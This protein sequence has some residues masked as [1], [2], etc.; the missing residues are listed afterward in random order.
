VN[1][2]EPPPARFSVPDPAWR[3]SLFRRTEHALAP[4]PRRRV[5][6]V[7][8]NPSTA[9]EVLNDPT[10]SGCIRYATDWEFEEMTMLNVFA[11]RSTDP[12][13]LTGHPD[14]IGPDNDR[15]IAEEAAA[16]DL[17]VCCWG[18]HAELRERGRTVAELLAATGPMHVL[19][20]TKDGHPHHP[21]GLR[22]DLDPQPWRG[23]RSP[24]PKLGGTRR[25]VRRQAGSAVRAMPTQSGSAGT[26]S[27]PGGTTGPSSRP[28]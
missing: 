15:W 18:N 13:V 27:P 16:A 2:P 6:F 4:G 24:H 20:L 25:V 5:A 22:G 9:D 26:E 14:P 23:Y 11:L 7:G 12:R 8:L 19:S 3:Y 17:V 28:Y 10:V 1:A 21:R